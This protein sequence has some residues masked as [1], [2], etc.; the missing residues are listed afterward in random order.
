MFACFCVGFF[1]LS[2][3]VCLSFYGCLLVE[4]LFVSLFGCFVCVVQAIK[5]TMAGQLNLQKNL[6][7][8]A[9]QQVL[10]SIEGSSVKSLIMRLFLVFFSF[11]LVFVFVFVLVFVLV[12][13]FV[14]DPSEVHG[15]RERTFSRQSS[16]P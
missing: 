14:Q 2:F 15:E 1:C 11:V 16:R 3:L 8:H 4:C 13:L 6:Q 9:I 12:E 7:L 10:I 5:K